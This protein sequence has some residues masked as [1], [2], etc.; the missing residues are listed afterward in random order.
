ME[1]TTHREPRSDSADHQG[2]VAV[3]SLIFSLAVAVMAR[4]ISV[5]PAA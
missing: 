4:S 3:Y 1:N 5:L 2:I